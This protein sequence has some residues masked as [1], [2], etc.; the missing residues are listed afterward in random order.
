MKKYTADEIRQWYD[1]DGY[2]LN[3]APF[4]DET[5]FVRADDS[6]LPRLS[7]GRVF[8]IEVKNGMIIFKEGCD[9]YFSVDLRPQDVIEL[10]RELLSLAIEAMGQR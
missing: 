10:S 8:N 3:D 5:E 7:N 1:R 6:I 2:V 9:N 4:M